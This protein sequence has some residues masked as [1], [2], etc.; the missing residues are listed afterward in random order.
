MAD[1]SGAETDYAD[2]A[3]RAWAELRRDA[4]LSTL[5]ITTRLRRIV[6]ELDRRLAHVIDGTPL[7]T[8]GDYQVLSVLRRNPQPMQPS[9]LAD[10]LQVTRSGTTGRLHRLEES[11]LIRRRSDPDDARQALIS[12]TPKGIRLV[13][14]LFAAGQRTQAEALAVLQKDEQ[15]T[16]ATLLR[17]ILVGLQ[18]TPGT[19]RRS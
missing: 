18:D 9:E 7:T 10:L 2:H 6:G 15:K 17:R 5:E 19:P 16:L 8:Y 1:R 4:D 12:L 11:N 3:A 13:D 14:R